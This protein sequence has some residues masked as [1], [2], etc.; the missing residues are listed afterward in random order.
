MKIEIEKGDVTTEQ[1]EIIIPHK[2]L[3]YSLKSAEER[4][5]FV[6]E[7]L[8]ILTKDQLNNKK[9]IEILSDYIVSAMTPEEKKEKFILT[10]NRMI[11]VNKRETSFQGLVDKFENGEDGLWNLMIEND[12]NILLTH[13]KEITE[14]DLKEIKDLNDLKESIKIVEQMER[15]ATGKKKFKLKKWL[16]EMHQEQYIIKDSYKPMMTP[17]SVAIK[18]LTKARLKEDI[19]INENGEPESN[20]IVSLFNQNHVCALLCNYS[21]LK[22]DCWGNFSWD[23]WYLMEDL[24]NLIEDTLKNDYPLYYKLLIYKIDGKSNIEIQELLKDEFDITYTVEYLSSLWRNKIP[25]M[26]A[27]KAKENYLIWYYTYKEYGKW[28]RCSKCGQVKLAHNRFFSK[29]NTSKDGW[30]SICKECRNKKNKEGV[31]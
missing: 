25:K 20:C 6:D 11:T 15:A 9:Y 2:K 1:E 30:Y 27:E 29:N 12:K 23:F 13:K 26:I 28:K 22:E 21:A 31:R 3:D 10:D 24:D 5:N 7:L 19:I 18:N 4:K 16:I 17:T 8:P 14:K